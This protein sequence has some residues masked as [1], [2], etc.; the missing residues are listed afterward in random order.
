MS[1]LSGSFA[2]ENPWILMGIFE[3]W[4]GICDSWKHSVRGLWFL[5]RVCRNDLWFFVRNFSYLQR[6][7]EWCVVAK[8]CFGLF[9]RI[10]S[11]WYSCKTIFSSFA[12]NR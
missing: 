7:D 10:Y 12:E 11:Q 4:L 2:V 6:I 1:A 9:K 3:F 5:F 8:F